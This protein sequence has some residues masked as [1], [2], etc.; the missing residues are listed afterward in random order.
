MENRWLTWAKR[1]Q[2]ISSSGGF[3]GDGDFDKERYAEI[4]EIA[5][6]MLASLASVPVERIAQLVPDYAH[7]YATPKIDVRAAIFNGDSILLVKEKLD[8]LWTM[9]GGYAD[10]GISPAGNIEKEVREEA[11]INVRVLKLFGVFHKAAHEY[12]QDTRDFYKLYFICEQA[13][14]RKPKPG[15]ETADVNF[16]SIFDLP[17]LSTGRVIKKHILLA[18]EHIK[19]PEMP[20]VFD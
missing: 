15:A 6:N 16:F 13:G 20:T 12:D 8:G 9:P 4:N 18:Y 11:G 1:L 14:S 5:S 17:P 3:F 10:V 19:N 7:G 2:A